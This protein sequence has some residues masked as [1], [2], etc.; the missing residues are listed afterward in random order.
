MT[1]L[2]KPL[3][4]SLV[5]PGVVGTTLA[6]LLWKRGHVICSV[7]GR[8]RAE[9]ARC[10][11]LVR[12]RNYSTSLGKIAPDTGL[13]LIATSDKSVRPVSDAVGKL[14]HLDFEHLVALHT[15][16]TLAS[17][18]L[19]ALHAKG[20][21]ILSFHPLQTFPQGLPLTK[22]V[23]TMEGITYGIEGTPRALTFARRLAAGLGGRALVIPK[24]EKILYHVA[25]V[26][27][28]N[29]IAALIGAVEELVDPLGGATALRHFRLLVESSVRNAFGMSPRKALTGPIARGSVEVVA[30]HRR[31]L[32]GRRNLSALYRAV[33]LYTV[34][35]SRK[36]GRLTRKQERELRR[37]LSIAG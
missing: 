3:R 31:A 32:R 2:K 26:V 7:I 16:G 5:G 4:V 22:L 21:A 35:L 24:K 10:A 34:E 25:G 14:R 9:A 18:E 20:S 8:R 13:L 30:R 17:D 33:G 15:S 27:A 37:I 19:R 23:H 6:L 1:R 12:C 28:S 36:A 11:K 29:Y